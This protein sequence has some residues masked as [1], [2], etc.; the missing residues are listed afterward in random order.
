M[1]LNC[2]LKV[3]P[4]FLKA[5]KQAINLI[6]NEI[7]VIMTYA[8]R[9]FMFATELLCQCNSLLHIGILKMAPVS[10]TVT[11]QTQNLAYK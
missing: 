1:S 9:L 4:A 5:I 11:D 7:T 8:G 6:N 2:A 10:P 3:A